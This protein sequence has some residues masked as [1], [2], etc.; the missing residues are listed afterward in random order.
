M[1]V[2]L[3]VYGHVFISISSTFGYLVYF[4]QPKFVMFGIFIS[5]WSDAGGLIFGSIYG[6]TPF[7]QSIS[8][9]KTQEGVYGA[10]LFPT[11]VIAPI[12]YAMGKWS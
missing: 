4:L 6:K 2:L 11:F 3:E 9:S 12:F 5:Q 1:S 10:I 7:A 8:P